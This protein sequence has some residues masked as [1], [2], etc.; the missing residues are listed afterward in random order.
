MPTVTTGTATQ[1]GNAVTIQGN[2]TNAG[3]ASD[4]YVYL[5]HGPTIGLGST[6]TLVAQAGT[7]EFT[8][9]ITTPSSDT[10]LFYQ[11][12]AQNGAVVSV[13][14]VASQAIPSATGGLLLKLLLRIILAAV[15]VVGI[16]IVGSR[17]GSQAMLIAAVIGLMAFTIIDSLITALF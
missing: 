14:V 4:S 12:V 3:V 7:G 6:T 11:A 8:A 2:V 13:G 5:R 1:A 15:I 16:A 17:G 10:T 9:T